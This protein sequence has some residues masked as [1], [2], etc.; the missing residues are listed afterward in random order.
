M[1]LI[2]LLAIVFG[3]TGFWRLVE[4][5]LRFRKGQ[6]LRKAETQQIYAQANS[7][8]LKNWLQWS[9]KLEERIKNLESENVKLRQTIN[10]QEKRIKGLEKQITRLENSNQELIR[11]WELLTKEQNHGA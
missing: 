7:Q 1:E 2:K 8:V 4:E 3:V 5:L 10:Q 6:H 9:Q 11:K